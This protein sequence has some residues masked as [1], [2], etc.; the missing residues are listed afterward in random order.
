MILN[1]QDFL[2]ENKFPHQIKSEKYWKNIIDSIPNYSKRNYVN[3]VFDTVMKKQQ[4][5]A[6]DRQMEI[7]RRAQRGDTSPYHT[8][9]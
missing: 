1:Y 9:N 8:K 5:F 4:G 7:L 3:K 6:S 2:N